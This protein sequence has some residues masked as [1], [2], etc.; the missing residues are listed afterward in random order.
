MDF[1]R[2]FIENFATLLNMLLGTTL[3]W[4][5]RPNGFRVRLRRIVLR[6]RQN[7]DLPIDWIYALRYPL[8]AFTTLFS[9]AVVGYAFIEMNDTPGALAGKLAG[10]AFVAGM[11]VLTV[12]AGRAA[13]VAM[14]RRRVNVE[15]EKTS[16]TDEAVPSV[17]PALSLVR[18]LSR[19]AYLLHLMLLFGSGGLLV[20]GM[21]GFGVELVRR[22]LTNHPEAYTLGLSILLILQGTVTL[23]PMLRR[24]RR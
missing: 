10:A 1:Y 11:G 17:T 23:F 20:L 2:R 21:I 4:P 7:P 18:K 5:P 24:I 6:V 15:A 14:A 16:T 19:H 9:A 8:A 12:G 22:I 13:K 3:L